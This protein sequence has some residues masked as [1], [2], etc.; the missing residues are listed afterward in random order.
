[1]AMS[2]PK[3]STRIKRWA[4][5][6][7]HKTLSEG[8]ELLLEYYRKER[9]KKPKSQGRRNKQKGADYMCLVANKFKPVHPK[10]AVRS[11]YTGGRKDGCDVEHTPYYLEVKN[12][13]RI[14]LP[15]WWN[16]LLSD[17]KE[18]GD[19]RPPMVA[20]KFKK[21]NKWIEHLAVMRLDDLIA[22]QAAVHGVRETGG[23]S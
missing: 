10:A 19:P 7:Q 13:A 4:E 22:L 15:A 8:E 11:Q 6:P 9:E 17:K 12:C 2:K 23:K 18:S 1:M 20:F 16:Q 14:T 5:K 3:L 21:D